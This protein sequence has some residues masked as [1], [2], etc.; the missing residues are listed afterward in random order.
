MGRN[1]Y[2]KNDEAKGPIAKKLLLFYIAR[3]PTF[4]GMHF[5]RNLTLLRSCVLQQMT[6]SGLLRHGG[7]GAGKDA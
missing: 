2:L 5:A 3:R 1:R 4:G 7:N 6:A